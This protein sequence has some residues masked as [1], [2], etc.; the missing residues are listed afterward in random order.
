MAKAKSEPQQFVLLPTRGLQASPQTSAPSLEAFLRSID[1]VK[2]FAAAKSFVAG[3]GMP[4]LKPTFRVLDSVH[5]DGAKLVEM[6]PETANEFKA[7][8][9]GVRI[10]PVV[11]FHPARQRVT[12]AGKVKA[13]AAAVRTTVTV[14]SK[15]DDTPVRGAVV[16]AFTDFENR[17]G[18][19]ATTGA[20]GSVK[21][22]LG[23]AARIERLYVYGPVGFWGGFRKN[24]STGGQV[25]VAV[26]PVELGFNDSVRNYYGVGEPTAGAG[27]TVGVVDTGVG[28]HD[29]LTVS[30]GANTVFGEPD[31]DFADNGD[32]HGTHVA[33][34]IA[35][36][37]TPPAGLRG[38]APGVTLRSYRVFGAGAGGASNFAIAKAISKAV[39]DGCD[40]INLSLG[41]ADSDLATASAI[42]VARQNGVAV[43][44]AT[45][46][47]D[48]S[49]VS[50][51]AADPLCLAVTALGRKGTF[52]KGSV[53]EADV[54]G[55][56]GDDADEFIAAFSNVGGEVDLT[57]PGV[58]VLSTVPGGYQP[59][60]GTSMACPAITGFTARLLT[61]RADILGLPKTQA[62]SDE[63]A[64]LVLLAAR[65]RG[66]PAEFEGNG[67]PLPAVV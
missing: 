40:L 4:K 36:A 10:V 44:A 17:I 30:G 35:A 61:G 27:V 16:V 53:E 58:G 15:A 8:Q 47:D 7:H 56:F 48:R 65:R 1:P 42:S 32:G 62:R 38:I 23:S 11:Y 45:G 59:M 49:P 24:V 6:T 60:S 43:F 34:I 29:D 46:N 37:G 66:F 20:N 57:G 9:P 55:P 21:L 12:I 2:T 64:R 26:H 28:P 3:A 31:A 51:P 54:L 5:E 41:G 39:E 33:G 22:N 52:P 50:F 63:I 25:K 19:Q 14:R 13:A 18:A 67:L